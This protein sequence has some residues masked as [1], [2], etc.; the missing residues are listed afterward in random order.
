MGDNLVKL[1]EQGAAAIL[2]LSFLVALLMGGYFVFRLLPKLHG[3]AMN[4]FS[5]LTVAVTA[6]TDEQRKARHADSVVA[7]QRHAEVMTTLTE[8]R[9]D[10]LS[11]DPERTAEHK[12]V[13]IEHRR[14]QHR[15]AHA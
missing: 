15:E 12:P 10:F 14:P 4:A 2:A 13:P 7:E 8:I 3:Q 5:S 1:A 6:N 9:R 11:D